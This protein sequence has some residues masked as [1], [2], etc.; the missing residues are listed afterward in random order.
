M[1]TIMSI[2]AAAAILAS[3][4]T[5]QATGVEDYFDT[6][7]ETG[8]NIDNDAIRSGQ[9]LHPDGFFGADDN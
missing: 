6:V 8:A 7:H 1:K 9:T 2:F 4:S 3:V 5:A